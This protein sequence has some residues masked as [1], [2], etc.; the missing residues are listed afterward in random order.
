M[1]DMA[2]AIAE[3][4]N[5]KGYSQED[6]RAIIENSLKQAYKRTFGTSDNAI[7]KFEDDMSDVSIYSR[8]VVVDGVYDP[9]TEIELDEAK[10]LAANVE[11]G[12]EIDIL[13]DPKDFR[14]NAVSQGK[15]SAISDLHSSMVETLYNSYSDKIGS[16]I[17]G[18]CQKEDNGTLIIDVGSSDRVEGCLPKDFKSPDES[19]EMGDVIKCVLVSIKKVRTGIRLILS[20]SDPK[21]VELIMEREIPELA[22]GIIKVEKAVREV[23]KRCKIAVSTTSEEID[24]VGACVGPKGTRIQNV[25]KELLGEKIDV[26][27]YSDDDATFIKNSLTP[28]LV[29]RV[30][31]LDNDKKEAVAIVPDDQSSL[32]IGSH[33]LN[34]KLASRLC[35][36]IVSVKSES[37]SASIDFSDK[38]TSQAARDLFDDTKEPAP[39][40]PVEEEESTPLSKLPNINTDTLFV[41]HENNIDSVESFIYAYTSGEVNS[42]TDLE[43]EEIDDVY[44]IIT[45]NFDI[46]SEESDEEQ[47]EEPEEFEC[48]NCGAKVTANMTKCPSCGVEFEFQEVDDSTEE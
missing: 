29:S 17:N 12:D 46:E 21:L 30:V 41:L 11:L 35:G 48:P 44:K 33:G 45:E 18:V 5:E 34:V 6:V 36:W 28:A 9:V 4:I 26:L 27:Q 47:S 24:P 40:Q 22:Q 38:A 8:R 7:V 1:S 2:Q 3:L 32:A 23:G 37:E 25:I 10:G 19:Y 13:L 14:R 15:H 43:K 16:I 42:I 39:A 31:I 20:R